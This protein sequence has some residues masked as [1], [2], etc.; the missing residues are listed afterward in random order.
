MNISTGDKWIKVYV[1]E[2]EGKI[3]YSTGI[4]RKTIKG[5]Y[6]NMYVKL[7]FK[8]DEEPNYKNRFDMKIKNAFL[9]F[10]E[11]NKQ[12][13]INIMVMEYEAKEENAEPVQAEP[14]QD[15]LTPFV[16]EVVLTDDDL[17]F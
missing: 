12:R 5:D 6:E 15:E 4:S 17:P 14:V 11:F 1:F 13:Y 16:E 10:S 8:K 9:T 3:S 2:N 7:K